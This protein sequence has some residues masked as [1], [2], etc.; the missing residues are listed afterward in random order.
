[1]LDSNGRA[2][3]L[4]GVVTDI[5]ERKVLEQALRQKN[6][7]LS[8]SLETQRV[9]RKREQHLELIATHDALTGVPN[10]ALLRQRAEHA[11]ALSKRSNRLLAL[12][13]ID[14]DEFKEVNDRFGH[15]AGDAVLRQVAATLC[16]CLR[17]ADTIARL[18]G[19]E[20]VVVLEDIEGAEEV[21]QVTARMQEA[22]SQ[23]FAIRG[24]R[25]RIT[26]SIGVTLYPRDAETLSQLIERSDLAMYR[27]KALGRDGVQFYTP[28][29]AKER[30]TTGS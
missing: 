28:D 4:G 24:Q 7:E 10:R 19:D 15:A 13:F 22:L 5:T 20:F 3:A 6:A 14:L 30:T 21:E 18:G 11:I 12:L 1:L 8:S 2:T 29:L 23:P 9:L 16:G 26:T 25:I 27:A 17:E